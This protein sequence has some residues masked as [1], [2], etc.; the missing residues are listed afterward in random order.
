MAYSRFIN[1][2]SPT[3]EPIRV[4]GIRFRVTVMELGFRRFLRDLGVSDPST[5]YCKGYTLQ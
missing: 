5:Y 2:P 1:G 4:S 3:P